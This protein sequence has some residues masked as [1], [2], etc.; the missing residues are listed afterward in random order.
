MALIKQLRG[1]DIFEH[2]QL[3]QRTCRRN[4]FD[5]LPEVSEEGTP[6]EP[7]TSTGP[8]PPQDSEPPIILPTPRSADPDAPPPTSP[9]PTQASPSPQGSPNTTSCSLRTPGDHIPGTQP[10]LTDTDVGAPPLPPTSDKV[11]AVSQTAS[12]QPGEPSASTCGSISGHIQPAQNLESLRKQLA[13]LSLKKE[14]IDHHIDFL[15]SHQVRGTTPKGLRA[16]IRIC[17]PEYKGSSLET[18]VKNLQEDLNKQTRD[19]VLDHYRVLASRIGSEMEATRE[20]M[21]LVVSHLARL[22]LKDKETLESIVKDKQSQITQRTKKLKKSLESIR[23]KKLSRSPKTLPHP[24][25]H[26]GTK[27]AVPP[28]GNAPQNRPSLPSCPSQQRHTKRTPTNAPTHRRQRW[29]PTKTPLSTSQTHFPLPPNH[30]TQSAMIP[31]LMSLKLPF[32]PSRHQETT[33]IPPLMSLKLPPLPPQHQNTPI[34]TLLPLTPQPFPFTHHT[35]HRPPLL[36]TPPYHL[37][38]ILHP[39]TTASS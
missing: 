35:I 20:Q 31:S 32:F 21:S 22:E 29:P 6:R 15:N 36:P 7:L 17:V 27:W 11:N 8:S 9:T 34:P 2:P 4:I 25:G 30:P 14:R 1:R 24:N 37:T 23:E 28:G 38:Y 39:R 26:G 33:T 5:D 18:S 19:L 16:N 10:H 3:P 13:K 12:S